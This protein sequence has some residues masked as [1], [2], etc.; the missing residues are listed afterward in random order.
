MSIK[1]D[2]SRRL[3]VELARLHKDLAEA[4]GEDNIQT[5]AIL[6]GAKFNEHIEF[7]CVVLKEFGGL[8]PH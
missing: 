7:I 3:G 6:L 1:R 8:K 4:Q 5:A 2:M